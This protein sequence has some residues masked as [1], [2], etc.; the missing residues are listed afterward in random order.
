[1]FLGVSADFDTT[2]HG[3]LMKS[4][5]QVVHRLGLLQVDSD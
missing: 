4:P 3:I 2:N 5:E 1:M